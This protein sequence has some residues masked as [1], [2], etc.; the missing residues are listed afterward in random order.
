MAQVGAT[1]TRWSSRLTFILAATGSA[2]GLGNIWKFP[3]E[4]G[5]NGGGAF[6]LVYLACVL[7][8]GLPLMMGEIFV[9]RKGRRNP[10]DSY[11]E[12]A[13]AAGRTPAWRLIGSMGIVTGILILSFYSVVAGWAMAYIP[14]IA[15]GMLDGATAESVGK[16]LEGLWADS[17]RMMFWHSAFLIITVAIVALGIKG[18]LERAV[19]YLMPALAVMMLMLLVYGAV[20][21]DFVAALKFLFTPDF[22]ALTPQSILSAV[23]LAFFSLSLGMGAVLMYG[24]YLPEAA[25]IPR[26]AAAVVL[27]DTAIA[28]IA[29]LV[30]FPIVFAEQLPAAGGPGLVFK[31]LP[32][33]FAAMPYGSV[34]G[35]VFMLLLVVAAI[36]SAI[37]LLE[38]V[39]SWSEQRLKLPRWLA[40]LAWGGLIWALGL[41]SLWSMNDWGEVYPLAALDFAPCLSES[42]CAQRGWAEALGVAR[43]TWFGLL[44]GLTSN[45]LLPL[46]G[47]MLS[48]FVGRLLDHY[49]VSEELGMSGILYALWNVLV[50]YVARI[51]IILVF[52]NAVGILGYVLGLFGVDW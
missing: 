30:I 6:V 31:T 29:G 13:K 51:A 44:D 17:D 10:A 5:Q 22:S 16:H 33:A 32:L 20:A 46:G 18:G 47:L 41:L 37:S 26:V 1:E 23:G 28:L 34:L 19:K 9:G 4:V 50:R 8:V 7:L 15:G 14:D 40:A 39:V 24:A 27:A 38:P 49:V 35:L 21:G 36:T 48:I 2:V 45:V 42:F 3:Y 52:L 25:S 11:G 43:L 12:L